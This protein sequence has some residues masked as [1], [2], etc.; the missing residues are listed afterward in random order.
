MRFTRILLLASLLALIVTPVA[1]ALRFTDESFNPPVGVTGQS[2]YHKFGGAAGCGPALPYQYRLLNGSLP[3]GLTLS[4]DGT[5]SGVPKSPGDWSFWVELSDEDPPSQSWCV[6]SKAERQF[7]I[8]VIRGLNILQNSLAKSATFANESYSFQFTAEGGGSQVWSV[9]SGK[10]P[11]GLSLNSSS[12]LL[13]GTPTELGDFTFKVT[14]TDGSRSDTETYTLTVVEK[15]NIP[16]PP[17][18]KSEVGQAFQL[19]LAATGGRAP[20]QWTA[21]GLPPGFTLDPA[22]GT[23][24]GTPEAPSSSVVKVTVTDALNLTQ[25][26]NVNLAVAAKLAVAKK[27]LPT[28]KIGKK[29]KARLTVTGGVIPRTWR[30][31]GGKPGTLPPGIQFNKR[32]GEF[33]GTPTKAGTWRLR[34]QIADALGVRA[35][36]PVLLKVVG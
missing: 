16:V 10:L 36:V 30:I 19:K 32:T 2:C 28:L 24:S 17:T 5:I 9:S 11:A 12:G 31:L 26:T 20:Y 25:S 34:L 3:D 23:I 1:L 15:L 8:K 18:P 27:A 13:S 7:T 14:V 33:S 29:Y 21:E 35:A 6:P 4:K 22:T